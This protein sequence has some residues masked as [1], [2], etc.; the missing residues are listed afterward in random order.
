MAWRDG[1]LEDRRMRS[2]GHEVL[3]AKAARRRADG[4]LRLLHHNEQGS[5]HVQRRAQGHFG[6][7]QT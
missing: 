3:V 1:C 6:G 5:E 7:V 4:R 2:V